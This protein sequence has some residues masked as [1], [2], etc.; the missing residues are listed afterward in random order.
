M[1]FELRVDRDRRVVPKFS[2]QTLEKISNILHCKVA[3]AGFGFTNFKSDIAD[4]I[5]KFL[6]CNESQCILG[7]IDEDERVEISVGMLSDSA[8]VVIVITNSQPFINID[9][10]EDLKRILEKCF[11]HPDSIAIEN[12]SGQSLDVI[13]SF[14]RDKRPSA[15]FGTGVEW[16][17]R[18][19]RKIWERDYSPD[20]M[21]RAPT[22][23]KLLPDGSFEW[24]TYDDFFNFDA[25]KATKA[26]EYF[27]RHRRKLPA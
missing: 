18:V 12:I 10:V 6:N 1:S 25:D 3:K 11:D 14:P 23:P 15:R 5:Q 4:Q 13:R 24:Y 2:E 19:S 26:R 9:Q 8:S 17:K 16:Y 21:L 7:F 20:V 27:G 22:R